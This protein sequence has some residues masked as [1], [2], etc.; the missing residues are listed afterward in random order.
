MKL[1]G[2]RGQIIQE[3]EDREKFGSFWFNTFT[4][5]PGKYEM[6]SV[7]QELC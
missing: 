5:A 3:F 4:H 1:G 6:P 2:A 7:Y